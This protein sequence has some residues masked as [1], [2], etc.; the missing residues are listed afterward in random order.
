M[1]WMAI[2]ILF[3]SANSSNKSMPSKTPK[4]IA[5]K[6]KIFKNSILARFNADVKPYLAWAFQNILNLEGAYS[7]SL[8]I[9]ALS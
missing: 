9:W 4:I 7:A 3:L 2:L 6:K 1:S 8:I 5:E